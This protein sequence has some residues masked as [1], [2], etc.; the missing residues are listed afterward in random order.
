[1]ARFR[2]EESGPQGFPVV[3]PFQSAVFT[4]GDIIAE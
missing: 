1:M 2:S 4:G 3:R